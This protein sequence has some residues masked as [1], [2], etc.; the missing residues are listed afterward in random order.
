[1]SLACLLA[2][3]CDMRSTLSSPPEIQLLLLSIVPFLNAAVMHVFQDKK[4]ALGAA[5]TSGLQFEIN[6]GVKTRSRHHFIF[7]LP[8]D[9]PEPLKDHSRLRI[10]RLEP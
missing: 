8:G 5:L 9:F 7:R 3:T 4:V 2:T 1:M 6:G 10:R